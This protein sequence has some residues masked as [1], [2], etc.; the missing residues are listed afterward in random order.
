MDFGQL[1]DE[2]HCLVGS[3]GWYE[4]NNPVTNTRHLR[5]APADAAQP[6]TDADR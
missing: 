3:K 4:K 6:S 5:Q 2:M 1:T